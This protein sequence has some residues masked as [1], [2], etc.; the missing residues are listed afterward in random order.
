MRMK[1][2]NDGVMITTNKAIDRARSLPSGARFYRCALQIN[3]F[4]YVV[5]HKKVTIFKD[6][7]SYN[8]AIVA[9]L[10]GPT[11]SKAPDLISD[12]STRLF[13]AR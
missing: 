1:P 7:E 13:T 8:T 11:A 12:S 9:A 2:W 6:E 5:R 4:E 3:P 10:L